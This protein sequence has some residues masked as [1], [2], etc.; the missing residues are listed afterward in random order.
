VCVPTYNYGRFLRD[1]V[2]SVKAQTLTDWELI[3]CDDCS[4]DDTVK[5]LEEYAKAD[6][7]ITFHVNERR[8]GMNGNV[9]RVA[10]L[11]RGKYLKMLCSDDWLEPRALEILSQL[12]EA[13]PQVVVSTP[14]EI[15]CDA[16]GEPTHLQFLFG[17]PVT[18]I[19][20]EA[21]LDRMAR[22]EGFGGHSSFLIRSSAYREIGGY[23]D[24]LLYAADYDLGARLC[25]IGDYLHVD[26]PL[27]YARNQPESSSTV[28]PQKL[29]DVMDWFEIPKKVFKY[30]RL[31]DREWRRYQRIT[32]RLTARY[33]VNTFLQR[34][35]GE[36][37]YAKSLQRLLMQRGN[38]L[39]GIPMLL[40]HVP[41]RLC[42]RFMPDKTVAPLASFSS[43]RE[44]ILPRITSQPDSF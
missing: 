28:N 26:T 2:E 44:F 3:V 23:D 37:L 6:A 11:G 30:Q 18:L 39:F 15:S 14:A 9:K 8:L 40:W 10:E 29:F 34:L 20:G 21:M 19:P 36:R 42:R 17:T 1:C 33:L 24:S 41:S 43:Q 5:I 25:R 22:G 12:M 7:R 32:G 13:N 35:R 4:T 31:G 38:F 27:L 16:A